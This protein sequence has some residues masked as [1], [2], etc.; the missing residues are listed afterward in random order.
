MRLQDIVELSDEI[1][2]LRKARDILREVEWWLSERKDT[3][4]ES[5]KGDIRRYFNHDSEREM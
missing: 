4:P 3:F 1:K 2:D 5:L